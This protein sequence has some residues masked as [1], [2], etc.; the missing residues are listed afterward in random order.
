MFDSGGVIIATHFSNN[1]SFL[2]YWCWVW[3]TVLGIC[4]LMV[5]FV[6]RC[7]C[8]NGVGCSECLCFNGVWCVVCSV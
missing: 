5:W 3:I 4:D 1:G 8:F 6:L 7:S 2:D